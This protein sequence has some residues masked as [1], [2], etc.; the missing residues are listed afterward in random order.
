[1]RPS[2]VGTTMACVIASSRAA[3]TH[4]SGEKASRYTVRR[5]ANVP[6]STAEMP[7]TWYGG[8]LTSAAS[9]SPAPMNSTRRHDVGRQVAVPQ[10][11]GLGLAGR[12]AREEQHGDVVGVEERAPRRSARSCRELGAGTALDRTSSTPSMA[13]TR[14]AT[15]VGRRSRPTGA[16]RASSER[17]LVVGEPV[18][19]RRE[20]HAGEGAAE[21]QDR[22]G[23]GVGVDERRRCRPAASAIHGRPAP[24]GH[25]GRRRSRRSSGADGDPV[26]EPVGGHVEEHRECARRRP[27]S[28]M[29]GRGLAAMTGTGSP[30]T[31]EP[32]L[33][34]LRAE[35][36]DARVASW[37]VALAEQR[38][39]RLGDA[40]AR[41]AASASPG[42]G[43]IGCPPQRRSTSDLA[44]AWTTTTSV[45]H[46]A[47]RSRIP[48]SD[49]HRPHR[50]PGVPV[51]DLL[52]RAARGRP[53]VV[54]GV[55]ADR[56]GARPG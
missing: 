46:T 55:V 41:G 25:A 52:G 34:G 39:A 14:P 40:R 23:L 44:A 8:T 50:L 43:N 1:M 18:V 7:A 22:H 42:S 54:A 35:Q 21:Q 47:L 53:E 3:P 16:V 6:E 26:A 17:E 19:E 45:S 38:A 30:P 33:P 28:P 51:G 15:R 20:R 11:G 4:A 37:S 49:V 32:A 5:P 24:P 27:L 36:L 56:A 31:D 10:H 48:G 13:P 9:S 12:A 2:I 29:T